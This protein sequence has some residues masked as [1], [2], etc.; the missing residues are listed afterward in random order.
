VTPDF[1]PRSIALLFAVWLAAIVMCLAGMFDLIAEWPPSVATVELLWLAMA[2]VCWNLVL[3]PSA[4]NRRRAALSEAAPHP[5]RLAEWA[6][7]D[8]LG[9]ALV[10]V[11]SLGITIATGWTFWHLPPAY[12]DEFSYLFE[13]ELLGQGRWTW[14]S[15]TAFPELFHQMHVLNEGVMASRYY[16]GTALWLA[17]WVAI[18]WPL[19]GQWLAQVVSAALIYRIAH[20]WGGRVAACWTGVA[21]AA[22]PGPALF[23][24]LLLSHQ[25]TLLG[26]CLFLYG[27]TSGVV[28]GKSWW[29]TIAGTGLTLAML[30]RPATAA[31]L[32]FPWGVWLLLQTYRHARQPVDPAAELLSNDPSSNESAA[33]ELTANEPSP[34]AAD[35]RDRSEETISAVRRGAPRLGWSAWLSLGLPIVCG[36]GLMLVY[37]HATTGRWLQSP[38]QLYTQVYTPRHVYGLDNV[39]RGERQVGPK[40]L[41]EYDR[42]AE[43]LT[44]TLAWHNV[45]VRWLGSGLWTIGLPLLTLT[46]GVA[47]V[48]AGPAGP[49]AL[50]CLLSVTAIHAVHW[51]YWYPG[52]MGWHYV[53]ETAPLW[54]LLFGQF[55]ATLSVGWLAQ[56]RTVMMVWLALGLL[57]N[58][59]GI[60]LDGGD[61]WPSRWQRAVA[62]IRYPKLQR[63]EFRRWL[64]SQIGSEPA[65][66]LLDATGSD[67]HLDF[68]T[69]SP[70]MTDRLIFGRFSPGQTDADA[71][72]A[73]FPDR[74][75]FVCRWNQRSLQRIARWPATPVNR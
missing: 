69:N 61:D 41:Q 32:A 11:V 73:A 3:A 35:R 59:C 25:A 16:P 57:I 46:A 47:I 50:L 15:P 49:W 71:V 75:V 30:S 58:G 17:P 23:A 56:R 13:A 19:G 5:K 33:T 36:W 2:P 52:I 66:I 60:Y 55:A 37:N 7:L 67:P 64:D 9:L 24:N 39:V 38:Y 44:P 65:L 48:R 6:M 63:A 20:L 26:A 10:T 31:S 68:V 70:G 42:W 8:W 40:T 45:A 27:F 14:P 28:T 72:A 4:A 29:W 74:A 18:G 1:L 53:F 34:S 21:F 51:P 12:H 62:S 22:S 43:N 54:C